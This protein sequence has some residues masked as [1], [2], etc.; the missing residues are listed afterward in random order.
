M[1]DW[2]ASMEQSF[3]YYIVDPSTWGDKEKLT[4]ITN[5]T[6]TRDL[7]NETLG[8]ATI[9]SD[10]DL[11]DKY[12]RVYL[13]TKQHRVRESFCLGTFLCQTSEWVYDGMRKSMSYD[14][15]TPLIELKE[16]PMAVGYTILKNLNLLDR[17]VSIVTQNVRA[18]VVVAS[19][20]DPSMTLEKNFV[21]EE[22][23][24]VFTFTR[25]LLQIGKYSFGLTERGH[26]T[27]EPHTELGALSPRWL[28]D[29][30]NSSILYPEMRLKGDMFEIPNVVEVTY[31]PKSKTKTPIS[32]SVVNDDPESPVSTVVRGRRV[33]YRDTNPQIGD[34]A[35]ELIVTRYA[36]KIL[37][38]KSTLTYEAA[39]SHGFT[40]AVRL[41]DCVRLNYIKSGLTNI[42]ARV[43]KQVIHCA[44]GCKVD[45]T[46]VYTKRLWGE[47][48]PS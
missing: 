28:F 8:S 24:T 17:A 30:S 31:S 36:E 9:D 40:D 33:V 26:I 34:D 23:D 27:F 39:Y 11:N 22:N 5:C 44:P 41:G 15:Y 19:S 20:T 4:K 37:T 10:D 14:G 32:V 6:I 3:E 45:E 18:P 35:S 12:V 2:S 38:E 7:K 16:K 48:W 42:N 21:A 25:D 47:E 13:V 1:A 43:T 29:D 46:A